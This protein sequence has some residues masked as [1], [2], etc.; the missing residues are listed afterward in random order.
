[1]GQN[2]GIQ[3]IKQWLQ[4][5]HVFTLWDLSAWDN[6]NNWIDWN[7]GDHPSRLEEEAKLLSNLLEGKA[8]LNQTARDKRSWGTK[9]GSFTTAEGYQSLMAVPH[10]AP[11]PSHWKF[12]WSTLSI[13]KVDL[14]C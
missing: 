6:E 2:L 12:V 11:N 5:Q 10:V 9:S 1:L 7:L 14:F 8:P 4:E 3:N 13:L